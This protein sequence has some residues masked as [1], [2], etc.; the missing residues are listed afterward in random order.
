MQLS[1]LQRRRSILEETRAIQNGYWFIL[2]L[3]ILAL[4][5]TNINDSQW[6]CNPMLFL[7][8]PPQSFI[9]FEQSITLHRTPNLSPL[10]RETS[11][12]IHN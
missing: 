2:F 9:R 8:S 7:C 1:Q 10:F 6:V 5:S 4:R 11:T 3:G 12:R